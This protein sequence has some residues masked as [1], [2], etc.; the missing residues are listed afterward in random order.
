MG[1]P[2]RGQRTRTQVSCGGVELEMMVWQDADID[3]DHDCAQVEQ[4]GTK[5]LIETWSLNL[6]ESIAM[7]CR[8]NGQELDYIVRVWCTKIFTLEPREV[9]HSCRRSLCEEPRYS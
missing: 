9:S 1:L 2:A 5:R 3:T 8:K 7:V 6:F 4:G